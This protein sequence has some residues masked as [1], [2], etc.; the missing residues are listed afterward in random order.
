MATVTITVIW[1]VGWVGL[2]SNGDQN[3]ESPADQASSV[4]LSLPR[5]FPGRLAYGASCVARFVGAHEK[6]SPPLASPCV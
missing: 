1:G 5:T 3:V 4:D 2:G 6:A